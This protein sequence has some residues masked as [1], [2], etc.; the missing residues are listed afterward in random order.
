MTAFIHSNY[1]TIYKLLLISTTLNSYG[2]RSLYEKSMS[3]FRNHSTQADR[4]N[5]LTFI[6]SCNYY[7][8]NACR[9]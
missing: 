2:N 6:L 9:R 3:S 1:M 7:G 4:T 5:E 8:N